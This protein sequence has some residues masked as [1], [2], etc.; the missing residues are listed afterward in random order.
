MKRP[1][2]K[3]YLTA[4]ILAGLMISL[5]TG[6]EK[7]KDMDYTIEGVIKE[8]QAQSGEGKSGL[9]QFREEEP[10]K[11]TWTF[12]T[13]DME[14]EGHVSDVETDAEVNAKITVPKTKQMSVVQVAEPEFD[15]EYKKMIAR[16]L[17]E[18][19]EIESTENEY[20]GTF[21]G[22]HY[23][24]IFFEETGE[25]E[26]IPSLCKWILLAPKD[27]HDVSPEKFKEQTK[28]DCSPSMQGELI[29]NQCKISEEEAFKK[30]WQFMEQLGL[31]YPVVSYTRPL[32]WGT[33]PESYVVYESDDW[34]ID[35]YVF[36]FDLGVDDIS[37]VEF[38]TEEDYEDFWKNSWKREEKHYSLNTRLQ[39]YVTDK[40]VIQM[41]AENPLEITG[42][43][44]NVSLLPLDTI[45]SIMK[46]ELEQ[47][48]ET[49]QLSEWEKQY[50]DDMELIYFRI[51]DK[52]N[53]DNYC[54]V[55]AWRLA[56][57]TR[58]EV[59]HLIKIQRPVLI[60]AIDGSFINFYDET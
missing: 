33:P 14:F 47:Q 20:I 3:N 37:F 9:D 41:I 54:Y 28:I 29:K 58:D 59:L 25:E 15:V 23:K 30:A 26:T 6:C 52:E 17:F 11:E 42:V 18:N 10:W 55:P 4:G 39:V 40:G 49:F 24:L 35:G 51:R 45:K 16:R 8:N 36:S 60:N 7:E 57:V 22:M 2:L 48:W 19:E 13:G 5:L 27:S 12:K 21:Q 34:G 56:N 46:K 38:G 32:M 53:P 44:E 50:F 31:D 43:S 1:L